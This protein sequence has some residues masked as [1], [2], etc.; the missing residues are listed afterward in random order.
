MFETIEYGVDGA[1]AVIRLN[2]P[3]RH[4]A[5]NSVMSREL[6]LV[7]EHFKNDRSAIVAILTGCGDRAFCSGADVSDLPVLGQG[8]GALQH[9]LRWTPQQNQVWKPVICAVNGMTVGGGLHFVADSDIVIASNES[10]FFDSH[11]RVGLVAGLEP[12]SLCRKIPMESVLRMALMGGGER[13]SASRA[14]QL[15]LISECVPGEGLMDRALEIAGIIAGNSPSAMAGTKQAIWQSLGLCLD[16]ALANAS[17]II[18]DNNEGPD[19][20][21]GQRAFLEHRPPRWAPY[22]QRRCE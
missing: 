6:P 11:V 14:L 22:P 18:E 5:I 3:A 19:Y 10:T 21:E 4:N 20:H 7:W 12:V 15:G 8:D 13:L 17:R 1:V 9:Q 2:R 16:A